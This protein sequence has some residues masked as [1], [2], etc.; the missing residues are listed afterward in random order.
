MSAGS[1]SDRLVDAEASSLSAARSLRSLQSAMKA[2]ENISNFLFF[3]N[4][5]ETNSSS[6]ADNISDFREMK[7]V[8]LFG[9]L[10]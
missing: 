8:Q 9:N 4:L 2:D 5:P 6:V 1:C 3:F 10:S 7:S